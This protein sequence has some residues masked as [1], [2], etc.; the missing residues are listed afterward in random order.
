MRRKLGSC[1]FEV[2]SVFRLD[3]LQSK[4]EKK[5]KFKQ[6]FLSIS[7]CL[8]S[9]F[10]PL[11]FPLIFNKQQRRLSATGRQFVPTTKN[12]GNS[13]WKSLSVSKGLHSLPSPTT[14]A[15]RGLVQVWPKYKR[16]QSLSKGGQT[17]KPMIEH[18]PLLG[19]GSISKLMSLLCHLWQSK[20]RTFLGEKK[21]DFFQKRGEKRGT[22]EPGSSLSRAYT[23]VSGVPLLTVQL[24]LHP[25]LLSPTP[26]SCF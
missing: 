17:W 8:V 23:V 6:G 26:T 21:V 18:S 5:K 1:S 9:L 14:S 16:F 20:N 11:A 13:H 10:S 22:R 19:L 15:L 7:V 2:V 12:H 24:S 3:V 4:K 25:S